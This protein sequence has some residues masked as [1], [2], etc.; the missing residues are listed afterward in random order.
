MNNAEL[1]TKS[2]KNPLSEIR[3]RKEFGITHKISIEFGCRIIAI[4]E[5]HFKFGGIAVLIY[6]FINFY[7]Y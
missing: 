6:I 3:F 1:L 2:Y 7:F 5:F 4:F